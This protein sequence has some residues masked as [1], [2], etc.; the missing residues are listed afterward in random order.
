M[1]D[2]ERYLLKDCFDNITPCFGLSQYYRDRIKKKK[3]LNATSAKVKLYSRYN[4]DTLLIVI[5]ADI[6]HTHKHTNT[7]T[8]IYICMYTH[9]YVYTYSGLF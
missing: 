6:P 5:P 1:K 7:R 3:L 2:D 4:D 8:Y 9:I